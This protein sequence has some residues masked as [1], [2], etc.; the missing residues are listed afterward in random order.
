[1]KSVRYSVS[2]LEQLEQTSRGS[3]SDQCRLFHG[4]RAKLGR[5]P[6][7][8][9][10]RGTPPMEQIFTRSLPAGFSRVGP[11]Q[12]FQSPIRGRGLRHA[13]SVKT[14]S[15]VWAKLAIGRNAPL[16]TRPLAREGHGT[17]HA[18]RTENAPLFPVRPRPGPG[19]ET[20]KKQAKPKAPAVGHFPAGLSPARARP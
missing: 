16:G 11:W 20:R 10:A 4:R 19:V 1:M 14:P 5:S 12:E 17:R 7:P 18:G 2:P 15:T 3:V 9:S 13:T 8:G 6:Q